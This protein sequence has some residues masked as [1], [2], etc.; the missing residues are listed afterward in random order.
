MPTQGAPAGSCAAI[1][2]GNEA[3]R[4]TAATVVARMVLSYVAGNGAGGN[5]DGGSDNDDNGDGDGEVK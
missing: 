2:D 5:D 3:V 4:R 1:S